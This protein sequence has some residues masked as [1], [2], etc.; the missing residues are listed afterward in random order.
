M[1]FKTLSKSEIAEVVRHLDGR[2]WSPDARLNR[3][4]FNLSTFAALRVSE[5]VA[6]TLEDVRLDTSRPEID[7]RNGKGSKPRIVPL[8][9]SSIAAL[10]REWKQYRIEAGARPDDFLL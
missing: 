1:S 3:V 6:T 5:I 7:V 2:A 9:H 8:W 10:L 4:V